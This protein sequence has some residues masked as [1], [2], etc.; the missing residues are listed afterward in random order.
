MVKQIGSH[1]SIPF[2]KRGAVNAH[3]GLI[4]LK[5][6]LCVSSD[7]HDVT[8]ETSSSSNDDMGLFSVVH[9]GRL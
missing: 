7:L 1:G 8:F 6:K 9:V 2:L 3:E 5:P 4:L